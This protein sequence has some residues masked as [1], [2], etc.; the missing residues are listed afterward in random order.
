MDGE[1]ANALGG[2]GVDDD[3]VKMDNEDINDHEQSLSVNKI[4]YF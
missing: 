1:E 4:R 2:A 3:D